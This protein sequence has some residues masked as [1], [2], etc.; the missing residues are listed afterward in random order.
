MELS[1][2]TS[3][4]RLCGR[5]R[6]YKTEEER[7]EAKRAQNRSYYKPKE[8]PKPKGRPRK[9]ATKEERNEAYRERRNRE[10]KEH[11]E[12]IR[13]DQILERAENS[14]EKVKAKVDRIRLEVAQKKQNA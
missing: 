10:S 9:Y 2:S 7:I 4:V 6:K 11:Y 12:R 13:L 3:A 8:N 1:D 5:P 14:L